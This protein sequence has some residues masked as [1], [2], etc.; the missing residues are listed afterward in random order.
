M[1]ASTQLGAFDW[2]FGG[3]WPYEPRIRAVEFRAT[4]RRMAG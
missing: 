2:T 3:T 4:S 1:M